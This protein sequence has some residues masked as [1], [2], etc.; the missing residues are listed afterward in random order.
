ME[1]GHPASTAPRS[2]FD[3]VLREL[4]KK[5]KGRKAAESGTLQQL[6][7]ACKS[8]AEYSTKARVFP[9][10]HSTAKTVAPLFS[11][12]S[13]PRSMHAIQSSLLVHQKHPTTGEEQAMIVPQ[14]GTAREGRWTDHTSASSFWLFCSPLVNSLV[15]ELQEG[16]SNNKTDCVAIA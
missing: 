7:E 12:A 8:W 14:S 6:R 9:I 4:P 2:C 1:V 15:K 5:T 13:L 16:S 3:I 11:L 10:L